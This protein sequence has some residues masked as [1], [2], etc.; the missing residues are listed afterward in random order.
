[1]NPTRDPTSVQYAQLDFIQI[2][3]RSSVTS[4][5]TGFIGEIQKLTL[6][7][8]LTLKIPKIIIP[9]DYNTCRSCKND[10][11]CSPT[12]QPSPSSPPPPN[13]QTPKT[14]NIDQKYDIKILQWNCNGIK[15]KLTELH[16]FIIEHNIKIVVLQETKLTAKST[17]P[18][19]DGFTLIRKDRGRDK[20]GGLAIFIHKSIVFNTPDNLPDDNFIESLAIDIGNIKIINFYIPPTSSCDQGFMPSLQQYLPA[21]D[22]LVLGDINAH[23]EL[24]FSRIQ[25]QRGSSLADE[26]ADSYY[27]VLNE[28]NPTRL[29]TNNQ[30]TSPDVSLASYS[31]LPHAKWETVTSLGSDYLPIIITLT[32]TINPSFSENKAF[33]NFNKADWPSFKADIENALENHNIPSD[34]HKAEKIFR[35]IVNK[36]SRR[37][38]PGGRIKEVIPEIPT[39]TKDKILRRDEIR[40]NNPES[41]EIAELNR[42]IFTEMNIHK[43]EKW[44]NK[45]QDINKTCSSDLFK[46]IKN[47][48]GKNTTNKNQAIKFKGKYISSAYGLANAFNHQY[49]SIIRHTTSDTHRKIWKDNKKFELND[50]IKVTTDQTREEIKKAKASK[51]MGPDKI[52]NVHLKQLGPKAVEYLTQIFNLS[53]SRSVIPGIWKKSVV[54]PLLKPGK[55]AQESNSYRPVSLLCPA[56]KILERLILPIMTEHLPIPDFQHGFRKNHSTITALNEFNDNVTNGFNKK[57]PPDRTVLLQLDLSKAFDMVSHD[58]LI[59]DLNSSQLPSTLKRWMCSYLLGR[60]SVVN[61]RNKTSKCLNI[62]AGVPQ[63]A[64]TSPLLFNFYLTNLPRPPKG[65]KLIQYADDI[66]IYATGHNIDEL[67]E[68]ITEYAK[69]IS[70][71]LAERELLVSPE[72]STVT[73]FTPDTKQYQIHPNVKLNDLLVPLSNTPKLL[74]VTFDTMLTFTSHVKKA[75]DSTKTKINIMKSLAGSTWGQ[76]KDTLILT[77]KSIGRSVLEYGAP[78]WSPVISDSNWKKVQTTQNQALRIATGNVKMANQDHLHQET[79]VLPVKEHTKL[80]SEQFLLNSYLPGHPGNIQIG[81]VIPN[82]DKKPTI[83]FY[84]NSVDNLIPITNKKDL[85]KKQKILHTKAVTYTIDSYIPN[86][87]LDQKPPA[88]SKKEENLSRNSRVLLSQ[89]RSG[90]SRM[91]NSYLHRINDEIEDKCPKC[92]T[93]PHTT[94]HLFNCPMNPTNIT[95]TDLWTN[96]DLVASF[97]DLEESGVI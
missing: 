76:D 39:T 51:A 93:S 97:L 1:M 53:L 62:R 74:G 89:L 28:N 42:E 63:G 8:V 36:S 44:V 16:N 46:L 40:E 31:L 57:I 56:I 68:A 95:P 52:S 64:V 65:I 84:R 67:A 5:K 9:T 19:M 86:K 54:V 10:P 34:V 17:Q 32:S 61:F 55:S 18:N 12:P 85:K 82:R 43:H 37:N 22:S 73:L 20:G 90:Y 6:T 58:K 3:P 41:A 33:I 70:A 78:I 91:L 60:Q 24:W 49:C 71:F 15:N 21:T 72:K 13:Y 23:D 88:V 38:I 81:K 7:T 92:N 29:P 4:A 96:P 59:K 25:D 14:N 83:Q 80:I 11:L 69:E 26:I 30:P 75:V 2:P 47:L 48:N 87:V 45:V 94:E 79:K 27:G 50:N 35:Q 77:Y 66:S